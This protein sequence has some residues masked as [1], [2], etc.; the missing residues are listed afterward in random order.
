[1]D[2]FHD[3]KKCWIPE[4]LS[5]ITLKQRQ[6]FELTFGK[7]LN[8]SFK[9]VLNPDPDAEND[10]MRILEYRIDL[11][12]KSVSFFSG[13][14]LDQIRNTR[15][16]KVLSIYEAC[17]AP[18][19][20]KEDE[21]ELQEKYYFEDDLWVIQ[22]PDLTYDSSITFNEV[23]L[24]KQIV[25]EIKNF[26][27]GYWDALQR[28]AVIYFRKIDADGNVE[29][30]DEKWMSEGS[31]RLELMSK[32]PMDCALHVAFFLTSSMNS[33]LKLSPY[34]ES[35][36]RVRDRISQDTLKNGDG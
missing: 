11:A 8:E 10:E 20:L 32:L 30:F 4:S 17:L 9:D 24:G 22:A 1:M 23:I 5:Q 26:A 13:I 15:L 29:K 12:C 16:D 33:F 18:I 31:E 19:F 28:L 6:D 3:G 21:I 2:F 34:L 35:L 27:S 36:E 14:P 7:E 25:T